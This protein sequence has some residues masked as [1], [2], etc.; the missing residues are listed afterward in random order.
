VRFLGYVLCGL[1]GLSASVAQAQ[2][3]FL[4]A[5]ST[6]DALIT[7][8]ALGL[9]NGYASRY[10]TGIA[11]N[12]FTPQVDLHA[13]ATAQFQEESGGFF[14]GGASVPVAPYIKPTFLVGTSTYNQGILPELYLYGNVAFS[15][16]PKVGVV[17]MPS[18]T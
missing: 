18:F 6:A 4:P 14:V 7:G 10:S 17:V 3:G 15:T 11:A 5:N 16:P 9:T 13:Q 12:L 8:T 2:S 1:L